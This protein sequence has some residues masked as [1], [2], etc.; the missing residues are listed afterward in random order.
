MSILAALGLKA[1]KKHE[2]P[3]AW[4]AW[5]NGD[6]ALAGQ[7][8]RDALAAGRA[9]DEANRLL[10]LAAFGSGE[11]RTALEHFRAIGPSYHGLKELNETV[12][13]AYVH[14]GAIGEA[15]DFTRGRKG[16]PALT[17]ERLQRHIDRPFRVDLSGVATLPFAEHELTDYF[18]AFRAEMNGNRITAHLDTG[19]E[20][21]H[22]GPERAEALGIQT[23]RGGIERAHLDHTR[24]EVSYGIAAHFT[25]GQAVL[26]NV[27]VSVFSTLR[28]KS[29]FVIFGTNVLEQ[30]L[31]T[32]DYPSRRLI[33]S[34]RTDAS[35]AKEHLAMLPR[36]FVS[37]PFYLWGGHMMF[38]RGGLGG[39]GDLNF[40]VDS[41][42]VS[43]HPDGKG[44]LRQASFTS[45]KRKFKEWGISEA[46]IKK[47]FFESPG[48]LYLGPL[49]EE[50]PILVPGAAGDTNFGGV[51]IDGLISHGF[52]KRYSW[53]IDFDK[54]EYRFAD[55][56]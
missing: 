43:V 11:Y 28:G 23:V 55:S 30:F 4:T 42:L 56:G 54:R 2:L 9:P 6:V 19:G 1:G 18:P 34:K 36:Q 10:L 50:R 52:L 16:I 31:S 47:D 48:P 25:L 35:A 37:V 21:V 17:V 53:T 41:G 44:G 29:D 40:F 38:A 8:A 5:R 13:D 27:P 15:L 45:S 14:L 20:F 46:L 51:R 3:E 39:R 26:D 12:I 7:L 22:M 49:S 32:M 33:L 24:V